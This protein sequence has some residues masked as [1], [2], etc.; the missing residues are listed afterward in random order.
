[1]TV[2]YNDIY[3]REYEQEFSIHMQYDL[4]REAKTELILKTK[5][6]S[7]QHHVGRS[8]YVVFAF[9]L[10]LIINYVLLGLIGA[11]DVVIL[12]VITALLLLNTVW[13]EFSIFQ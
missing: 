12:I 2:S 10:F 13:G 7:I 6:V 4:E 1:M 8:P 3:G 11:R 9:L 5:S